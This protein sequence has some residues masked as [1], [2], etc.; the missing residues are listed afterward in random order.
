MPAR[1]ILNADDFGLTPGINRAVAELHSV[2]CLTSATLMATG[3]AFDDAVRIAHEHPA[4]GI[5]CHVVLVDGIPVSNPATLPT[6]CPNGST[7][8][9]KLTDFHRDLIFGRID[10]AE[11]ERESLA[12]MQKL[13]SAGLRVT[14]VDTHKHTHILPPVAGALL[15]ACEIAHV[16]AIRSPFEPAWSLP[17]SGASFMRQLKV[18]STSLFQPRFHALPQIRSGAIHTTDGTLGISATGD[19]TARTLTAMLDALPAEGTYELL[20]HPGYNDADL[21]RIATR[22]RQHRETELRAL[23][24][25][26]PRIFSRPNPPEL[27]SYADL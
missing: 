13:Q 19:L 14:H 22:L 26:I 24:A 7:F 10:A 27:I 8:R 16:Q 23:L 9:P 5:G 15:R 1:L 25:E 12:Q 4:L 11:I 17:I 18:R 21:D 6:L 20:C 2:G 3:P